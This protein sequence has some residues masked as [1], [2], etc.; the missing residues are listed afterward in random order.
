MAAVDS[1]ASRHYFRLSD[2]VTL[3]NLQDQANPETVRFPNGDTIQSI[4]VGHL[5]LPQLTKHGTRVHI[6]QNKDLSEFSLLAIGQLCDDGC[7]AHYDRQR[8]WVTD[9][10]GTPIIEGSRDHA[11]GLY[12]VDLMQLVPR[13]TTHLHAANAVHLPTIAQRVAYWAASMGAPVTETLLRAIRKGYVTLPGLTATDVARYPP[14]FTATAKGHLKLHRQGLRPT[15]Y[16]PSTEEVNEDLWPKPDPSTGPGT[17]VPRHR[18][19]TVCTKCLPMTQ[20]HFTDM[21]GKFPFVSFTGIQYM[22]IMFCVDANYIHCE[23]MTTRHGAEYARAYTR[24]IEFFQEHGIT[25]HWERLDNETSNELTKAAKKLNITIQYLPPNNHRASKAERAIQ[26]WKGHFISVLC[27]THPD[28]PMGAWN[29]LLEHTELTLNLLRGSR[30]N[31]SMSAWATLHGP[32]N[33]DKHPIAPAGTKIVAYEGPDQRASWDPHG[34]DGYYVGPAL[35]HYRCYNVYISATKRTRIADTL[36]WHP[37]SVAMPIASTEELIIDTVKTLKDAIVEHA[38]LP[39]AHGNTRQPHAPLPDAVRTTLQELNDVFKAPPNDLVTTASTVTLTEPNSPEDA[40]TTPGGVG[41]PAPPIPRRSKRQRKRPHHLASSITHHRAL[42]AMAMDDKGNK[43]RY[44]SAMQSSEGA[45]WEAGANKEFDRLVLETRTG[46]W[47]QQAAVPRDR[48]VSYYNPQLSRKRRPEADFPGGIEYR[49]R[50]TYGGDRGDY[51][52]PTTAETADITTVKLLLNDVISDPEGKWLTTDVCDYYLG[53]PMDSPEYMRVPVKYIP[54]ATQRKHNLETLIHNGAVIMQLNK[55]IYG[56]KQAGRLAQQRMIKHLAAHGYT[57]S[58]HTPCLFTHKTNS[59]KFTLVVDDFGV[60]YQRA[61]DAAH[62]LA[63]LEQLYKIKTNW[64]GDRY[65]GFDLRFGTCS[66]TKLR[67]VTLSMPRF[68]PSALKRFHIAPHRPVHNPIDYSPGPWTTKQ[69]PTRQDTS[70]PASAA[71]TTR[72][73]QIVGVLLYY[74]RAID[75]TLL[76][77]VSKVASAQAQPTAAVLAAAER[78]LM[79]A[80]THPAAELRYFASAMDLIVHGDA[81]YLSETKARSRAGGFFFLG[82]RKNPDLLNAPILCTSSILDVVVSSASEAEYGAAFLNT[83][84]TTPI[85]GTLDTLGYE[86]QSTLMYI[87]NEAA[88]GIANDTVTQKFSKAMDM[89]YHLV[90]DRVRQGQIA[91]TWA[92]GRTNVADYLTKAHPTKHF[93]AMRPFFVSTPTTDVDSEWTTVGARPKGPA[94]LSIMNLPDP[95]P[96]QNRVP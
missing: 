48:K 79:Y 60:K 74:A 1:G 69:T 42:T 54:L 78:L 51:Q 90:R 24:G 40:H 6:F 65:I 46:E 44:E 92:A 2:A 89:R 52:G 15:Q 95:R 39:A 19:Q 22:L 63:T 94:R 5:A 26:T 35:Q 14:N 9:H 49:V 66:A 36:S 41:G 33:F 58:E 47:I 50:G 62:L 61:E 76:T 30:V 85:R 23:P 11:T 17:V 34:V 25:P 59:V 71:D 87:D 16:E 80:A 32:I 53:T 3:T 18:D 8:V 84:Q 91:V 73:Q 37:H 81:S 64:E 86:Q 72:I 31:P 56:L 88:D 75:A 4:K 55:G 45:Q 93:A 29:H 7:I 83:K 21:A 12:M 20:E 28:F 13:T 38:R 10:T 77:A 96:P 82:D 68:L 43:L 27:M 57:Q 70:P 67:T